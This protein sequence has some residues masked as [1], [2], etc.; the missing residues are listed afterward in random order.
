M[1]D[2]VVHGPRFKLLVS[3]VEPAP[4]THVGAAVDPSV[5]AIFTVTD[6]PLLKLARDPPA[7][8]TTLNSDCLH[9]EAILTTLSAPLM[10]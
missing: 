5:N 1:P 8:P 10:E 2:A 7:F 3:P 6:E 4:A 9:T